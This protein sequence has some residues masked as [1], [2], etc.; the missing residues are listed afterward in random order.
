MIT[1]FAIVKGYKMNINPTFHVLVFLTAV[2]VFSMPFGTLAQQNSEIADTKSAAVGDTKSENQ[3]LIATAKA[4]AERDVKVDFGNYEQLLWFS[5][6]FGCSIFGVAAAYLEE[7]QPPPVRLLGKSPD[8]VK[9]YGHTYQNE[10]RKNQMV[11]SGTGC[12]LSLGLLAVLLS[13][14]SSDMNSSSD[15]SSDGSLED[16]ISGCLSL[17]DLLDAGCSC[18]LD[19]AFTDCLFGDCLF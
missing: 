2:L 6:G 17:A 9:I 10:L 15:N 4:D 5:A 16:T 1:D 18:L 19:D 7:T 14:S 13:N 3:L 12:V 8:Y 11:F